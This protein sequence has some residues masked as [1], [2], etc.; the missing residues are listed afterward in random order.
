MADNIGGG[1][2]SDTVD[3]QKKIWNGSTWV[4]ENANYIPLLDVGSNGSLKV[5]AP[6]SST[7]YASADLAIHAKGRI[8]IDSDG[9]NSA[10]IW[11][12]SSSGASDNF[13][14]NYGNDGTN[15]QIGMWVD[16]AWRLIVDQN[17]L[18]TGTGTSLGAWT[19]YTPTLAGTGWAIGNGTITAAYMRIGKT[20]EFRISISFG[21]TSTYGGSAG[22]TVTLPF[23]AV[24]AFNGFEFNCQL[25]DNGTLRYSGRAVLEGSTST[26]TL[27]A[28]TTTSYY[29]SL[30]GVR[31]GIPHTWASTDAINISGTYE[32]A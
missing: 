8:Q 3:R 25:I 26:L 20:V 12:G 1:S 16:G 9:S 18:I 15:S 23:A 7:V 13:L 14:G 22:P 27:Y 17:G 2:M 28:V 32:M 19:S 30:T 29:A 31:S 5:K 4:L 24:S 10:G 6:A 11:L 21:T